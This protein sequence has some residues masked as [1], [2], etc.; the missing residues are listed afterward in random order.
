M[1]LSAILLISF[2]FA[3]SNCEPVQYADKQI[4]NQEQNRDHKRKQ[5]KDGLRARVVGISDGDSMVVLVDGNRRERI[6]LATIDAPENHQAFGAPSKRSLSD[7]VYKKDVRIE[8]VDKDQYG[9][10]VGEVFVGDT[11]VNLEQLKRGLAW[12]YKAHARQQTREK[13]AAYEDAENNARAAKLGIW[14]DTNPMPPWEY[15]KKNPRN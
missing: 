9:R 6:R 1:K 14:K 5:N 2:T 10:I 12:H 11:N 13:R 4:Q 15:R 3:F 8:V 7:L